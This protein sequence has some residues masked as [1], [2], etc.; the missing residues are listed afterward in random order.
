MPYL[1]F[2]PPGYDSDR[3]ARFPALY[4]LHGLGGDLT[5]W[6]EYRIFE[7]ADALIRA[8]EIPPL[9]IVLPEGGQSY[10]VDHAGGPRWGTYTARDVTAEIDGRYRTLAD[11]D[12]RAVG[13]NSMGAHAALQLAM[14]FPDVFRVAGAH[15]PTLRGRDTLPPYFGDQAWFEAHDPATLIARRPEVA[16]SLRVWLDI[17]DGDFFLAPVTELHR[18]LDALG[19]P[20]QF[21]VLPGPHEDEYWRANVGRYLRFYGEAMR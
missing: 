21:H 11:P 5:E 2:L 14:N 15:S 8:G 13:G 6:T 17:G 16:R 19:I 9:L 18:R 7:E 1:V 20:H 10:W 4:M 12:H 3:A